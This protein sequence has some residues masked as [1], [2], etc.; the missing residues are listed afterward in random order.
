MAVDDAQLGVGFGGTL[1][2]DRKPVQRRDQSRPIGSR[3]AMDE[4][5]LGRVADYP[6]HFGDLV[7][8]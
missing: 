2:F 8:A 5:R 6:E 1:S 3:L 4:K 7:V